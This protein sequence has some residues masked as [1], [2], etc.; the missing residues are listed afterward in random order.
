MLADAI[1]K[2]QPV[3][4]LKPFHMTAVSGRPGPSSGLGEPI[5]WT[6][7]TSRDSSTLHIDGITGR[8]DDPAR[9]DRQISGRRGPDDPRWDRRPS[10][11]LGVT[12]GLVIMPGRRADLAPE[13][14][15]IRLF[16]KKS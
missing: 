1:P 3:S 4:G 9:V 8:G 15:V 7:R 16:G 12:D 2:G 6:G 14:Q 13:G 11:H 10:V 5:G